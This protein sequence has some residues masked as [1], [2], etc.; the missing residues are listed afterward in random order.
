M[1]EQVRLPSGLIVPK[2]IAQQLP[3]DEEKSQMFNP[4]RPLPV[5]QPMNRAQR[6]RKERELRK[7][8]KKFKSG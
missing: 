2:Y 5:D 1:T 8:L 4:E 7:I 6:R 3:R